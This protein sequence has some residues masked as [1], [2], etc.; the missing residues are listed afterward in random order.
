MSGLPHWP[1]SALLL[2]FAGIWVGHAAGWTLALNNLYGRRISKRILKPFRLFVGVVIVSYPLLFATQ[3]PQILGRSNPLAITSGPGALLIQGYFVGC[4]VMAGIFTAC[5]LWKHFRPNPP[6]VLETRTQTRDLWPQHGHALIGDGKWKWLP[7]MPGNAVFR[8]D[9]TE[10]TLAPPGLPAAWDGLTV[11][12][13]SDFHFHGT[14]SQRFFEEALA[15]IRENPPDVL[16]L[17]GDFLDTHHHHGWLQDI[18]GPLTW[19]ECGL[20]ILGNHDGPYGPHQTRD[21]LGE[22]GYRVI[23]DRWEEVTIRGERCVAIGHEGPWFRRVPDLSD[24][25]AEPYRICLSHTPDHFYWAAAQ[26]VGLMLCGHV[27]GG[28]IRMP[29]IGAIFV[30]SIYSRR[31]DMGYFQT[32]ETVMVVS[33]GLSGKEPIRFRCHPQVIRI[34]LRCP[35]R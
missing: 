31:F 35:E 18:L 34:T 2:L 9:V 7:R 27:H 28:Q 32:G 13:L 26:R 22:L 3:L 17:A 16:A 29:G 21:I 8:I 19:K 1:T 10:V 33:R 25:P 6:A 4:L 30:P 14:P 20:A 15:P 11:A 23:S 12:L 24:A 5:T